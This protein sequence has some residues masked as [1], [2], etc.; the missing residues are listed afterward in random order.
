MIYHKHIPNSPLAEYI[1]GILY[2]EGNNKGIGLPKT[3]MS[4]VFNLQDNFKLFHDS[5]FTAFT[6]YKKFWVAGMQLGPSYVESYGS[7]KMIV[8]QFKTI[9]AFIFLP[10]PLHLFTDNFIN[11]SDLFHQD[12]EDTWQQLQEADTIKE[13][14]LIT[15]VFLY[16]KL[17]KNS[18]PHGKLLAAANQLLNHTDNQPIEKICRQIGVSRKHLNTLFKEYTGVSTKSMQ[19]LFRFQNLLKKMADDTDI[20]LT[21][22]AYDMDYADVAHFSNDF[23]RFT[24][25][26]PTAYC[27][28]VKETPS[29]RIVP[30]FIPASASNG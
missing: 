10:H 13:K 24:G 1:D 7:S 17:L 25:I 29:M 23:K 11:L 28:L 5:S 6:D 18:M 15:E 14:F 20:H 26:H 27:K 2:I 9:G 19:L 3:A 8:V 4:L 21:D 12:A 22:L 16:Q 30:H